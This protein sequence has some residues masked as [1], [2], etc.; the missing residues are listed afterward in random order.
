[1]ANGLRAWQAR[2]LGPGS[3]SAPL[4]A[5][6]RVGEIR[7]EANLEYRFKLIGYL[8]GAL[9]TDVGNIWNRQK[10]SSRPGVEFEVDDFLSELAVGTGVGARLNF[11]F[12]IVRFDLGMQTKDPA[13]PVGERWIF[14][15]KDRYIAE[16]A[17][18]GNTVDYRARFN[19]NL[20]IGYPF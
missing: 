12:F 10:D 16:Q 3:Y 1:G 15:P 7:I 19:F 13:L 9:F 17:Q 5:F 11:D 18:L 6:D 14:Q 2:S 8:E 4:F 20:G